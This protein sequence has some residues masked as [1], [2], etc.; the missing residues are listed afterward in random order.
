MKRIILYAV[1]ILPAVNL[2]LP[3]Y[4]TLIGSFLPQEEFAFHYGDLSRSPAWFT[5]NPSLDQY[6]LACSEF[7]ELK[8]WLMPI[9]AS[10]NE[11]LPPE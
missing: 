6:P 11:A 8:R 4:W 1:L 9:F 5:L 7:L 2:L 10:L 3:L